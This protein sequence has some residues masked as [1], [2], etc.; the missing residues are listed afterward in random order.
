[1]YALIRIRPPYGQ[2]V[3]NGFISDVDLQLFAEGGAGAGAGAAGGDGAG[4]TAQG[5]PAQGRDRNDGRRAN[6]LEGMRYG[7]QPQRPGSAANSGG[8]PSREEW[9]SL[10]KGRFA[11]FY[12]EDVS[13]TV[14][15]RLKNSRNDAETLTKLKPM[16][17]GMAKK[18]GVSATNVDGLMAAYTDDDSLYE[19]EALERGVSVATLKSLKKMEQS[20][21]DQQAQLQ[22]QQQQQAAAQH[23]MRLEQQAAQLRQEVPGF[24]LKEALRDKRFADMVR[25]GSSASV[26][27]AYFALNRNELMSGMARTAIQKTKQSVSASIQ[28]GMNR[29]KENGTRS[30]APGLDVKTDPRALTRQDRE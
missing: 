21:K 11:K 17:E 18:Y 4:N 22:R 23:L 10:K 1:M 5:S 28:A 24:D 14:R 3:S 13:S 19:Q 9:E 15:D 2:M 7:V 25:P 12:G 27:D 30:S 26:A 20:T 8:E 29:P 6:P 16:L